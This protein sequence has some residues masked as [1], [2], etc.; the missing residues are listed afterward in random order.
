LLVSGLRKMVNAINAPYPVN[1]RDR[2]MLLVAYYGLLRRSELVSLHIEQVFFEDEDGVKDAAMT[3]RLAKSKTDQAHIGAN[4]PYPRL[5][6]AEAD[7][8]PVRALR[9]W[10]TILRDNFKVTKGPI[11]RRIDQWG[12]LGEDALSDQVVNMLVKRYAVAAGIVKAGE[13]AFDISAHSALRAGMATQ[14]DKDQQPFSIIKKAGRWKSDKVA[15]GYIRREEVEL[16][17]ALKRA[18]Q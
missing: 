14:L 17:D 5:A 12:H 4:L 15:R 8:C 10:L 9:E 11:F 1:A 6:E 3:I 2:T 18:T 13:K 16:R 7:V